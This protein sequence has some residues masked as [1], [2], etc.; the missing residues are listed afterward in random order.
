M[1]HDLAGLIKMNVHFSLLHI[2]IIMKQI[3]LGLNAIHEKDL[4]HRDLKPD[5]ILYNNKG[6]VKVADFNLSVN[7][8]KPNLT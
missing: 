7:R 8:F 3:F 2:K 4:I 6:E 5:N 1:E